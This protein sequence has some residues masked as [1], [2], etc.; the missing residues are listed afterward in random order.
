MAVDACAEECRVLLNEEAATLY[1]TQ[2]GWLQS[3]ETEK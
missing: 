3:T 1:F 2:H